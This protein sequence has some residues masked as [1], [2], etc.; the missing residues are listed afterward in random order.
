MCRSALAPAGSQAALP[1]Y[2]SPG[3]TANGKTAGPPA[4]LTLKELTQP[5]VTDA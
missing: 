2:P 1:V 3:V 4:S 5:A